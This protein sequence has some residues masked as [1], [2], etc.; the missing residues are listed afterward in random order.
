MHVVTPLRKEAL[1][2]GILLLSL[3]FLASCDENKSRAKKI[4][5]LRN[6]R[7]ELINKLY[8][9]YGGSDLSKSIEKKATEDMNGSS[10]EDQQAKDIVG[11]FT[12]NIDR[13]VFEDDLIMVAR[14]ETRVFLSPRAK[15][16]FSRKDVIKKAQKLY[17]IEL[18]ISALEKEM[19]KSE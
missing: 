18:E 2:L 4:V 13:Q 11:Q 19:R 17:E 8:A 12:H 3:L 16:F 5:S 10:P 14:G 15:E 7:K 6:D 1:L 9:E